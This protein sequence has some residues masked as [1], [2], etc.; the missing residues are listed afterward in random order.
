MERLWETHRGR[1]VGIG[2]GLLFGIIYLIVGLWKTFI[3]T[4]FVLAGFMAGHRADSRD[5]LRHVL[6]SIIPDKWFRK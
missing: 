1:I 3:F 4:L 2:A 6:E 5:D